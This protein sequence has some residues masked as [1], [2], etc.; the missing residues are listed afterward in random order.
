SRALSPLLKK[1][2]GIAREREMPAFAQQTFRD[3]FAQREKG[4]HSD[5]RGSCRR[6]ILWPDTF[7]NHFLPDTGKAA[8]AVLEDAG[9]TV[10]LP[11]HVLCCG[12]PLYDWGMLAHARKLWTRI[13]DTLREEIRAGT[14]LVGLE[15][16]CVAAFRDELGNLYPHDEDA[17]R[18]GRQT[19]TL[20]EYLQHIDYTPKQLASKA[21]VHLHCN[22]KAVMGSRADTALLDGLGLDYKVLDSGC[23]GMAGSFGFEPHKYR[24]SQAIGERVLLPAVREIDN[25]TL[26]IADGF[27]CREQVR[28]A[29]GRM[30]LHL[31]QVLELALRNGNAAPAS[32]R[33]AHDQEHT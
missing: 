13:L 18:L 11:Q 3:W 20:A 14:P 26:L 4:E 32:P 27:S 8:V 22:H 16:A 1:V 24:M 5:R 12:R 29:T 2:G 19:H 33:E 6:V 30:P 15:P 17:K 21:V 23:C 7:T 9:C 10:V 31:A 25:Q 28:Q